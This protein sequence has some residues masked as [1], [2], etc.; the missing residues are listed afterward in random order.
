MKASG[1]TFFSFPKG[2]NLANRILVLFRKC[3]LHRPHWLDDSQTSNPV[4]HSFFLGSSSQRKRAAHSPVEELR[5]IDLMRSRC[6]DAVFGRDVPVERVPEVRCEPLR[7]NRDELHGVRHQ[8]VLIVRV[9][10]HKSHQSN[11]VILSQ[12]LF[13]W[14]HHVFCHKPRVALVREARLLGDAKQASRQLDGAVKDEDA[15]AVL[16]QV[17]QFVVHRLIR[18]LGGQDDFVLNV[19]HLRPAKRHQQIL[20]WSFEWCVRAWNIAAY[21]YFACGSNKVLLQAEQVESTETDPEC[22]SKHHREQM[23][24]QRINFFN[25]N[26]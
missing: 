10:Q 15:G 12:N 1:F 3:Q 22:W 21:N 18:V 6:R 9:I 14:S 16:H 19:P 2:Q 4:F 13:G 7:C 23:C 5:D 11:G 17:L 8:R 20:L 24:S 26:F 25:L